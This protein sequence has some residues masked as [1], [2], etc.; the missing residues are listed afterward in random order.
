M[1]GFLAT[2]VSYIGKVLTY[3]KK[4]VETQFVY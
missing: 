1:G 3:D 2:P 4:V